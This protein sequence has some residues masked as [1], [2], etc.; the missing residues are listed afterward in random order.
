MT[1]LIII[2]IDQDDIK[3]YNDDDI[4]L[5]DKNLLDIFLEA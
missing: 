5:L 3:I 2:D 1:I 4:K